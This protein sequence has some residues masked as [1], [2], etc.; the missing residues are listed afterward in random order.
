MNPP[1]VQRKTPLEFLA[2][3][4]T[5]VRLFVRRVFIMDNCED[6]CPEWLG[7][8]K[9]VVDSEDVPLNITD[10][11]LAEIKAMHFE[12]MAAWTRRDLSNY[13]RLNAL[14]HS[15]INDAAKNPVLTATYRQVNARLQAL[16]FRSNQDEDKWNRAVEEHTAALKGVQEEM[17][18]QTDLA[19]SAV[20]TNSATAWKALADIMSGVLG[21]SAQ[22]S[23]A[24]AGSGSIGSIGRF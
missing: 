15:A 16:R 1:F 3:K 17:K 8:L 23:A 12:M 22:Q 4:K 13:Y 21:G 18:K 6:L 10:A 11:E 5:G 19:N 9:G 7:F 20:A 24:L 2:N 14:I